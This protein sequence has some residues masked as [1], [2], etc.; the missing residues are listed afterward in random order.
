MHPTNIAQANCTLKGDASRGV[1]DLKVLIRQYED[2]TQTATSE[3][4]LSLWERFIVLFTGSI[5]VGVAAREYPPIRLSIE[6]KA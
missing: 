4:K 5:F 2:G 6:N 1:S 3:W